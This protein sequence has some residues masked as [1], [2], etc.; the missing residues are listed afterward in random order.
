M[1]IGKYYKELIH[2]FNVIPN[3]DF[4]HQWLTPMQWRL[5]DYFVGHLNTTEKLKDMSKFT[6]N[7]EKVC[8]RWIQISCVCSL[9]PGIVIFNMLPEDVGYLICFQKR[10]DFLRFPLRIKGQQ[11]KQHGFHWQVISECVLFADVFLQR[12]GGCGKFSMTPK[13]FIIREWKCF[14]PGEP[15]WAGELAICHNDLEWCLLSSLRTDVHSL[16]HSLVLFMH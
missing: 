5:M 4:Y 3:W 2:I 8:K 13:E 1:C 14:I 7:P 10:L 6:T 15:W 12:P 11:L 9:A 16:M